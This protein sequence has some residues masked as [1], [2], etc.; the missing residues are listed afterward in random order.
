MKRS[1]NVAY[2]NDGMKRQGRA[3]FTQ[4]KKPS[5]G[6]SQLIALLLVVS[7]AASLLG[8]GAKHSILDRNFTTK[9]I[10]TTGNVAELHKGLSGTINSFITGSNVPAQLQG[11]LITEEQIKNDLQNA[12]N[13]LYDGKRVVLNPT[14]VV[15]QVSNNFMNL[16][17]EKNIPTQTEEFLSYKSNFIAQVETVVNNQFQN[18][19]L[20]KTASFMAKAKKVFP[21]MYLGGTV[22]SAIL[23]CLLLFQTRSLFRFAHYAGLA[24]VFSG[25]IVWLLFQFIKISGLITNASESIG[26]YQDITTEYGTKVVAIFVRYAVIYGYIGL[27]L[28]LVGIFGAIFRRFIFRQS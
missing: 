10:V 21:A 27:I 12:I 20:Q 19:L 16:A 24:F 25:A 2:R 11:N 6:F 9:Q 3:R 23:G 4:P 13:N 17:N 5:R 7:L 18:S 26:M 14:R 8:L 1:D 15:K 22:V 28:V